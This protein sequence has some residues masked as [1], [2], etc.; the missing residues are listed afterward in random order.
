MMKITEHLVRFLV[1]TTYKNLPGE[2]VH[3]AKR[4]IL[5]ALGCAIAGIATDKG[6]IAASI[7][8]RLGGPTES[9]IFGLGGKVSCSNA[10]MANGELINALDYDAISHV[11]PFAIPPALAMA[12]SVASSGKDVILSTVLAQEVV[13]RFTLALMTMVARLTEEARTPDVFGNSNEAIFG[14][15]AG[16]AKILSLK[17]DE[18]AHALGLAAYLCPLP[19]CKD[20]EETV[21]KSMIKYVPVGWVCQGAVTAALL[22]QGGFTGNP[23]VFDGEYGF[24]RFYGAER[25]NPEIIVGGLGEQWRFMEMAY[26]SYPCCRFFHGQLDA[27]IRIIEEHN[28]LP[29]DIERVDSHALPFV[30]NPAPYDVQTQVDVQFSL[31]FVFSAAAHRIRVGADWQDHETIADP[32]IRRFMSKVFMHVDPKAVAT[33]QKDPK[34]WPATVQVRANGITYT[35]ETMYP[36]GTNLTELR[37]TDEELMAKFEHNAS[38]LL[39]PKKIRQATEE[40]M[41]LERVSDVTRLASLLSV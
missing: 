19:V 3:E 31:P 32:S 30:A 14:A 21:P 7:S 10:A 13:K 12:E 29:E 28:L 38:R 27:F 22:A 2:V 4:S 35:E 41:S 11:H 26:K 25:W 24:W 40:I 23:H 18:M 6:K 39:T 37:A 20:W 9:T 1:E 16:A 36:R 8:R 33:K 34:S 15:T 17:S 5:D